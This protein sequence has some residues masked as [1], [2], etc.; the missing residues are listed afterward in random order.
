MK[1]LI[2]SLAAA[3][4]LFVIGC[5]E[6]SITDPIAN[7]PVEK[8][9]V[10]IPDTYIHGTIPIETVLSDPYLVMNSFYRIIG[11][12]EYDLRVFQTDP[13]PPVPQRYLSLHLETNAELQYFCTFYPFNEEDNLD[14][15]ISDV[16]EDYIP[17]GG[18]FVSLL[19]KTFTI[20]GRED[21]MVLKVRFN[22]TN[23]RIEINAMW[24]A[25]PNNNVATIINHY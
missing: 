23:D 25:L 18:N 14:G 4:V 12:M 15:F 7:Q 22:V 3:S 2:I 6:N 24:L 8:P 11:Q 17:L 1:N 20:Q 10:G 9:Q 13:M 5:Q 19:E 21:G 16:S